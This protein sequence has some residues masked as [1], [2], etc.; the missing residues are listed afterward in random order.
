MGKIKMQFR[1]SVR[2]REW[3]F[4]SASK[5][6]SPSYYGRQTITVLPFLTQLLFPVPRLLEKLV[7]ALGNEMRVQSRWN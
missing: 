7:T 1:P 5:I 2:A 6:L 3:G 4:L